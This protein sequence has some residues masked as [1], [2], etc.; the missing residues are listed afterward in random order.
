MQTIQKWLS[1][2]L[3]IQLLLVAMFVY[4]PPGSEEEGGTE[5]A[6]DINQVTQISIEGGAMASGQTLILTRDED[7]WLVKDETESLPADT[8]RLESLLTRLANLPLT[9]P[10]TVTESSHERFEVAAERFQRKI[11]LI[12]DEQSLLT[13][14][15]GTA[16]GVKNAHVRLE[17]ETNVYAVPLSAWEVPVKAS[18]WMNTRLLAL[19]NVSQVEGADFILAL[20][21]KLWTVK[22]RNA[23]EG[24]PA[25]QNKARNLVQGIENLTIIGTAQKGATLSKI[26]I[27]DAIPLTIT[28]STGI[29]EYFLLN[30][31][32]NYGI[33]SGE[34]GKIYTLGQYDYDRLTQATLK[35][36]SVP[37][38]PIEDFE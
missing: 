7:S 21:D 18:Q 24:D 8:I 3:G 11:S 25:D 26:N 29:S 17:N 38:P 1:A 28:T 36:L 20:E 30:A 34:E 10:V 4:E 14:Y 16:T 5:P 2:L 23:V 37:P 27:N 9:A 12:A 31:G 19:R 33:R 13:L 32:S 15:L 22:A 35:S 6:L